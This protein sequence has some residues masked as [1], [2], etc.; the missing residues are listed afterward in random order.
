MNSV[1]EI[2]SR[3]I[4][5]S[6]R[7]LF[8]EAESYV[9]LDMFPGPRVDWVGDARFYAPRDGRVDCV[10]CC[11]VLEHSPHWR[12]LIITAS[13]WL[14]DGGVLIITCAGPARGEHSG[15]DGRHRLKDGEYYGNVSA[16]ALNDALV[17]AGLRV[18]LCHQTRNDEDTQA[19]AINGALVE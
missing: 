2:G 16:D 1:I 19:L 3:D 18:I 11:E 17:E 15:Y 13:S 14:R 10:A 8:T 5:G 6:V 4:N 7:E 12:D 9:G